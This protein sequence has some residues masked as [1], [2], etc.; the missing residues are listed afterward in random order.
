[1]KA[2]GEPSEFEVMEHNLTHLHFRSWCKICVQS[3]SK[4]NPSRTLKSRRP[5][6]Q[7]D[8]SFIGDKPGEPQITCLN[9]VDVMSGLA[10]SVV[11]PCKGRSSRSVYAQAELRRFVLETG[12]TFGILQAT[13]TDCDWP[14]WRT[15]L[16]KFTNRMETSTAVC[17]KYA[18]H[19][20]RSDSRLPMS[21]P[22]TETLTS[23]CIVH[24]VHGVSDMH[25]G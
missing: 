10:L 2:P 6:L 4:Q 21:S 25:S 13:G 24:C 14:S 9:V 11:V 1:M 8:Y 19:F 20:V 18:G 23:P 5:V 22:G 16:P 12:R 7:K 3:K 17:W 15:F